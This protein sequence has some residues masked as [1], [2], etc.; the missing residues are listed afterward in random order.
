M[1]DMNVRQ[2]ELDDL[3]SD[4]RLF[5]VDGVEDVYTIDIDLIEKES[6]ILAAS[7]V[8]NLLTLYHNRDFCDQHPAFKK[9]VDS[10]I[11]SL[12]KLYKITKY[13]ESLLD[14]LITTISNNPS[15]A[16]LYAAADRLESKIMQADKEIKLILN[17]F[18]KLCTTYQTEINFSDQSSEMTSS[19]NTMVTRGTKAFIDAIN[20][21]EKE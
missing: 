20:A 2:P 13:N 16:S 18:N 7:Q 9:R 11:E 5:D 8:S 17:E 4:E 14:H 10:E 12:R 19:T 21:E 1:Y 15:N 6:G 3:L